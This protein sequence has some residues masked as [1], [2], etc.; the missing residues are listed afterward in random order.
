MRPAP[1]A[2]IPAALL[3]GLSVLVAGCGSGA[4]IGPDASFAGADATI[5]AVDIQFEPD[6]VTLP[7][8][9]P[10]RLL[11]DNRDA[12]VPHDLHVFRGDQDVGTS[13]TIIGPGLTEVRFGPLTPGNYQFQCQI[14]PDMI[15][16]LVVT[17]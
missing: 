13:P 7:A 12:G 8:G 4:A 17:P 3:L 2:A 1:A 11:L 9:Q 5:E 6:T 15:G 14:H 16:T 10:L